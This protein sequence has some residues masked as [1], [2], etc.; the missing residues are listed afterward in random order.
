MK[1]LLVLT[2]FLMFALT[3]CSDDKANQ[4]ALEA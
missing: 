2:L 1:K 4:E 3:G